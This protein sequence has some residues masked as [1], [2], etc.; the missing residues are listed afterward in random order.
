MFNDLLF[1]LR[2]L[3]RRDTVESE[4]DAELRFHFDKQVEK[5]MKS[6]LTREE[7][8]RKTRIDFGGY[9]QLKEE[10]REAHGVNLIETLFQDIRYGLRILGRTPVISCVAV[11][12]L[13]LGIGANTAIFSLIDTVMLRM[14]PVEKPDQLTQ[15]RIRDPRS[16]NNEPE[17]TFTNPLWEELRNRQ[18]FFSGIFAWSLTQFDL[19][20]GGAV[21]DVNGMFASGEYFSTLSIRPAAG[22]LITAADDKRGC[23]G[24]AVLSYGFWQDHFGGA[25]NAVGSTLSLDNHIF[26]VIGVSAPGFFGLEVATSLTSPFQFVPRKFSTGRNRGWTGVRGGG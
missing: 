12:S 11:L 24:V 5:H 26:N 9:E 4:A 19:A 3:F 16:P 6:G 20:Q 13:A 10:I 21:H 22:R 1:R 7:A 14:L 17:P 2:S 8:L 23:P 18:D 25:Q 15:V